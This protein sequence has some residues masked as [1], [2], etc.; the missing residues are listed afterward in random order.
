MTLDEAIRRE[1]AKR[2]LA[3]KLRNRK[4]EEAH[5][6]NIEALEAVKESRRLWGDRGVPKLPSETE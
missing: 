4:G 2:D 5:K 1:I 6:L 3:L